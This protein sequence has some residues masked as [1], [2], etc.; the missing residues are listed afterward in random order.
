MCGENSGTAA[1]LCRQLLFFLANYH[2]TNIL[3]VIYHQWLLNLVRLRTQPQDIQSRAST[4]SYKT[5]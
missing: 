2:A 5:E 3:A 1:G 4:N